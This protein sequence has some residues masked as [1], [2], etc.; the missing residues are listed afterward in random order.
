[1]CNNDSF[2]FDGKAPYTL[3]WQF[4]FKT[5]IEEMVFCLVFMIG[6]IYLAKLSNEGYEIHVNQGFPNCH[7]KQTIKC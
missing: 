3:C 1:M 2:L 4:L 6:N 5:E 7:H